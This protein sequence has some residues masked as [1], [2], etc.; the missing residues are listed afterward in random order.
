MNS[1]ESQHLHEIISAAKVDLSG[2]FDKYYKT[3]IQRWSVV[4]QRTKKRVNVDVPATMTR[5]KQRVARYG[6]HVFSHGNAD[7]LR[8]FTA[9][10][11]GDQ[12]KLI[13]HYV[14]FHGTMMQRPCSL[15]S[16]VTELVITRH[17]VYR[18]LERNKSDD[19]MEALR[20]LGLA[21]VH[22]DQKLGILLI[23]EG[24]VSVGLAERQVECDDGGCAILVI[25]NPEEENYRLM[26]WACVTYISKDMVR[27]WNKEA[28]SSEF[29][30]LKDPTFNDF[31]FF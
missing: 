27:H 23:T 22:C 17:A 2:K 8:V 1:I 21:I 13:S 6:V 7:S 5:L 11:D 20:V 14:G 9:S 24:L 4:E 31:I 28:I 3:T 26:K 30:N 29:P 25:E 16:V 12:F 15:D 18:W 10:C 19:V